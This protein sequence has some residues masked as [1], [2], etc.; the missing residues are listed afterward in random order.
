MEG[1]MKYL[2]N[3]LVLGSLFVLASSAQATDAKNYNGSVCKAYYGTQTARLKH[4]SSGVYNASRSR[5]LVNCPIIMDHTTPTTGT[6][7]TYIYYKGSSSNGRVS[8][9]LQ[10]KNSSGSTRQTRVGSRS[11]TGWLSIANITS[12]SAWGTL[13]LYCYLPK[14]GKISTISVRE[15]N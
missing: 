3:I 1:F 10:S 12:E 6:T 2:K 13:S 15:R 14:N 7:R 8:C 11:G 4:Y 5:T 9:Y